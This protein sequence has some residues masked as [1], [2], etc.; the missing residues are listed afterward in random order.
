MTD[1]G[2]GSFA[3]RPLSARAACSSNLVLVILGDTEGIKAIEL[4]VV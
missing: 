3:H 4:R 1:L 2:V